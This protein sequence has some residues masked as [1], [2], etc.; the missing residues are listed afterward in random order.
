MNGPKLFVFGI[1]VLVVSGIGSVQLRWKSSS[2]AYQRGLAHGTRLFLRAGIPLG[3]VTLAAG[4][5]L[6]VTGH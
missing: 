2:D 3:V 6:V 5:I 4:A 1:F